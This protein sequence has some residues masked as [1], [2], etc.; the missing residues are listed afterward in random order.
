LLQQEER[1]YVNSKFLAK[2]VEDIKKEVINL[3]NRILTTKPLNEWDDDVIK[4]WD[5]NQWDKRYQ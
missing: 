4:K 3:S 5:N 2:Q 1:D